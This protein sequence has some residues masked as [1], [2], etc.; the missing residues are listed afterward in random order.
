VIVGSICHL[1]NFRAA[2]QKVLV[3]TAHEAAGLQ[4]VHA[5]EIGE[6]VTMVLQKP[7]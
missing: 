5:E 7:A 1:G 2:S 4:L 6:W 3:L